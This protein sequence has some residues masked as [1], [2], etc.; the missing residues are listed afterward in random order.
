M[1]LQLLIRL[2]Q[3]SNHALKRSDSV[4]KLY[5]FKRSLLD[6]YSREAQSYYFPRAKYD[7]ISLS[8]VS[9]FSILF[10]RRL[11][12]NIPS[13]ENCHSLTDKLKRKLIKITG[14]SAHDLVKVWQHI[15]L[16]FDDQ[17]SKHISQNQTVTA[18]T[19]ISNNAANPCE[20]VIFA[21]PFYVT[22]IYQYHFGNYKVKNLWS[23]TLATNKTFLNFLIY[24]FS[25]IS[26]PCDFKPGTV[27]FMNVTQFWWIR[28]YKK[29][30]PNKNI[31]IRFH[32][33]MFFNRLNEKKISRQLHKLLDQKVIIKA[34]TYSKKDAESLGIDYQPNGVCVERIRKDFSKNYEDYIFSFIGVENQGMSSRHELTKKVTEKLKEIYPGIERRINKV[35][36]TPKNVERSFLPY[37]DYLEMISKSALVLDF[38]KNSQK[39]GLSFRI[40]EGLSLGKKI[41]TDRLNVLTEPFYD[42]NRI[43]VIGHDDLDKLKEFIERDDDFEV[44]KSN[45]PNDFYTPNSLNSTD[46]QNLLHLIDCSTWWTDI[47]PKSSRHK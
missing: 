34:E 5:A 20:S 40:A 12:A 10:K 31:I 15:D 44:S 47:I 46:P 16:V 3:L 19:N 43:F 33:C 32:D 4:L 35:L 26:E 30:H 41:I 22:D 9:V 25:L 23:I 17:Q 45:T 42:S 18:D 27:V 7:E 37:K 2:L 38:T 28:A 13:K 14:S 1:L 6:K 11:F 21:F 39:E 8:Q 29:Q 36:L 24:L